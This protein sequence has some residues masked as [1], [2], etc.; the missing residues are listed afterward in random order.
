MSYDMWLNFR[1]VPYVMGYILLHVTFLCMCVWYMGV[2]TLV[3]AHAE[4]RV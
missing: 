1:C 2:H 4:A 3:C